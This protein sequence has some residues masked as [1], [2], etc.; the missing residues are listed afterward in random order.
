MEAFNNLMVSTNCY[1]T[2]YIKRSP[3]PSIRQH[4]H[5]APLFKFYAFILPAN[6]SVILRV[7]TVTGGDDADD[8]C[9]S[10]RKLTPK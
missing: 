2:S 4:N 1:I 10:A 6:E 9:E 5:L 8:G 7:S 3:A